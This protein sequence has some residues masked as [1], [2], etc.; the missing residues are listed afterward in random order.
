MRRTDGIVSVKDVAEGSGENLGP[1]GTH[2]THGILVQERVTTNREFHFGALDQIE[3]WI[4]FLEFFQSAVAMALVV[5][6]MMM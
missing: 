3:R 5:V 4:E 6:V 1:N 2:A